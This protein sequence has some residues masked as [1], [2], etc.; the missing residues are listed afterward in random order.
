MDEFSSVIY[1]VFMMQRRT[2]L[3]GPDADEFIPERFLDPER[4]ARLTKNPMMFI[5]FSAGPRIVSTKNRNLRNL[6]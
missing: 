2:D 4:M 6:S 5:P 1:S 3:W